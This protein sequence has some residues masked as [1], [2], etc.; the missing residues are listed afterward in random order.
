MALEKDVVLN[1][2]QSLFMTFSVMIPPYIVK[3]TKEMHY[4]ENK[5]RVYPSYVFFFFF[6][7]FFIS[8]FTADP[9]SINLFSTLSYISYP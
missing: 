5:T 6:F 4:K 2:G 8:H 7:F 9:F 1:T 3:G